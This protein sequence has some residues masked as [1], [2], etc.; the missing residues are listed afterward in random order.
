MTEPL[1]KTELQ[2]VK[3]RARGRYPSAFRKMAV[4][5][6]TSCGNVLALSKELGVHPRLLYEWSDQLELEQNR[7]ALPG[8]SRAYE[9]QPPVSQ[10]S[11]PVADET[12]V[13]NAGKALRVI[14]AWRQ[15]KDL[16]GPTAE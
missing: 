7:K 4:E 15:R 16:P 11:Q 2:V 14:E 3:K 8:N 10:L 6:M 5:R 1:R 13:V 9:L 12:L